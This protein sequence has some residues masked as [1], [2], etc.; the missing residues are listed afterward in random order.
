MSF[1][2]VI[3]LKSY[4]LTMTS[5]LELFSDKRLSEWTQAQKSRFASFVLH[6]LGPLHPALHA[7]LCPY[8]DVAQEAKYESRASRVPC[9]LKKPFKCFPDERSGAW[10]ANQW[11]LV[12]NVTHVWFIWS[13][14]TKM[15]HTKRI[16]VVILF[17]RKSSKWTTH[18]LHSATESRPPNIWLIANSL[19]RTKK[20]SVPSP[21]AAT[22]TTALNQ[23]LEHD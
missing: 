18:V 9:Q 12:L 17:L 5:T 10:R 3:A 14:F 6:F 16:I 8:I 7:W 2:D 19:I 23:P 1:C 13:F 22:T 15:F 4:V 11:F 20:Q 21:V